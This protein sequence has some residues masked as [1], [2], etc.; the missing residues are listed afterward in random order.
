MIEQCSC[1]PY[2]YFNSASAGAEI[3]GCVSEV[4]AQSGDSL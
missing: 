4:W 2:M 3:F 1:M